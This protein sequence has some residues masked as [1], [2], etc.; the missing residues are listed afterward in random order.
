[1][2]LILNQWKRLSKPQSASCLP[3]LADRNLA[4]LENYTVQ[5][6]SPME[7]TPSGL[8][9]VLNFWYISAIKRFIVLFPTHKTPNFKRWNAWYVRVFP[10]HKPQLSW[11]PYKV[12]II[13]FSQLTLCLTFS[14]GFGTHKI[15]LRKR[16][17]VCRTRYSVHTKHLFW[18]TQ[19][20]I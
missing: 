19:N 2:N 13:T 18:D 7:G 14:F 11:T 9:Q 16:S 10:T 4:R 8:I 15:R 17:S 12:W 1:M 5:I 6:I 20:A 3:A